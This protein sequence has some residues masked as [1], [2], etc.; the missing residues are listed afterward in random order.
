MKARLGA[1]WRA[2]RGLL[3]PAVVIWLIVLALFWRAWTPIEG[4]RKAFAWDAQWEYWG[5]LQLEADALASGQLPLWN[6]H[7]RLGYPMHADPQAGLLY[8][9]Q[10]ALIG[11]A[12]AMGDTPY[13]LITVKNL[14]HLWLGAFGMFV[15]LRRRKLPPLPCYVG[16]LVALTSYAVL[17]NAP[18]AL[19]WG[20]AWIPLWLAAADHWVERPSWRRALVLGMVAA[21]AILAGAWA[22][23]WYGVLVVA[24]LTLLGVA[25]AIRAAAPGTR[26]AVA[27]RYGATLALAIGVFVVLAGAQI[28]ST[29]A[30]VADT[31]RDERGVEFFGTTAFKGVDWAGFFIPRGL[32]ENTYLG[33]GPILW[34]LIYVGLR[35]SARNLALVG[36][37]ILSIVLAMGDLGPVLPSLASAPTPFDLFRRAHRYLYVLVVPFGLLAAEGLHALSTLASDETRA[38]VARGA[39]RVVAV[40]AIIFGVAFAVK[41]EA[42]AK[43]DAVRDGFAFG[44]C[45]ALAAGFTTY[46][47]LRHRGRAAPLVLALAVV[48]CGLDLWIARSAKIEAAFQPIPSLKDDKL[49]DG[50]PGLPRPYRIYDNE[51]IGYRPG[52]RKGLRDLGGYEGDPLALQRFNRVL[53]DVRT[54]PA[55]AAHAGIAYIFD[56]RRKLGGGGP[57]G[58]GMESFAKTSYRVKDPAADVIWIDAAT[59]VADADAAWAATTAAPPGT[60]AVLERD[61]VPAS[62]AARATK[63]DGGGPVTGRVTRWSLGALRAEID[64]PADGVVVISE[65]W[66]RRGWTATVD[67]KA[68]PI[69]AVNGFARGVLVGPGPHVIEMAYAATGWTIGGALALLGWL[70]LAGVGL[71]TLRR[72]RRAVRAHADA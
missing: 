11:S 51:R 41:L 48:V 1:A 39:L 68:A 22:G 18:S 6:P 50:L 58:A 29:A 15:L 54:R 3:V 12:I 59:I 46:L 44:L 23:F 21:L 56:G 26:A 52:I 33:W 5:D 57:A 10:W 45:A 71:D 31:V 35:P 40:A 62:D 49:L 37:V 70:A 27:R 13:W 28:L 64:A 65:L 34:A 8:P 69:Y 55:H 25:Q 38:K 7:D 2:S 42:P 60:V 36:I 24:P 47:V 67:G 61:Q 63:V 17:H 19:D 4:A 66:H 9:P 32:G 30:L 14:F 20:F 16:A 43:D 72:R 53:Q